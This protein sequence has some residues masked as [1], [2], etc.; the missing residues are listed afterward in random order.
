MQLVII[1]N[2]TQHLEIIYG[3][4]EEERQK[5]KEV[6]ARWGKYKSLE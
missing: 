5:G 1:L 3:T 4:K 6:K 2:N